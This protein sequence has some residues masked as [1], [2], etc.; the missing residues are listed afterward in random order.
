MLEEEKREEIKQQPVKEE[1]APVEEAEPEVEEREQPARKRKGP[2]IL[3]I[4]LLVLACLGAGFWYYWTE[5]LGAGDRWLAIKNLE[6]QEI[7]T[8]EDKVFFISGLVANGSTKPRKYLILRA[9]LYDKD[10]TVLA[11]KDIVAGLSLAREEVGALQKFDIEKKV[12]D[13]KLSAKEG[14]RVGSKQQIP[15]SVV[16]FDEGFEKAKEFTI[17][18]VD[19]PLL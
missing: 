3:G 8:K 14:F 6:G 19:S 11:E 13:F 9:K 18:I 17:E 16:F 4:V 2:V 12:N 15:F 7:V 5:Y 10:G 1:A